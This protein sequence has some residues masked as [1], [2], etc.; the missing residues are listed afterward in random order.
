MATAAADGTVA[1]NPLGLDGFEF[2]EFTSPDPESLARLFE[3]LGFTHVA[4][5]R[6][7]NVRR[8]AQGDINF[9]LNAEP[10]GQ[11][12]EFR[13]RH[14][15]SANA[16]AF[17]VKDAAHAFREAV[18]RGAEPVEGRV[19]PMELNIPAIRGIGGAYLYLV[20]RYGAAE[21]YDVDF[22]PVPGAT[23]N[24]RSVGLK[25]IDHLTHNVAQGDLDRWAR[26]YERIFGFR[27]LRFFDIRGRATG[28]FSKAMVAP[29]GKI[30]I[31]L[32]ESQD[33]HSQIAEFLRQ[34]NGEGIQHVALATDDILATV[35]ALR[36]NGVRFQ[37]TPD[38]YYDL[39]DRR[40]P[41]HG[42]DVAA[43]KARRILVDGAPETGGGL[44]LQIFTENM[45][46]PIFFEIIQRMGNDGFGEG[47]F[48]ALFESLELDQIRRGVIPAGLSRVPGLLPG[49]KR[50]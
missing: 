10:D 32:N 2:V 37:D 5:H 49:A 7:K 15:P 18:R 46:G 9:I 11:P 22:R 35:D 16:L 39:L 23:K 6:S 47:N 19:G 40:L 8:Y 14:G 50:A 24:D 21:I 31:P 13:Q 26:F 3:R 48:Q 36:A 27:E 44:L 38:V 28:L 45:V 20:D 42:L 25:T 1:D 41:G 29:D 4:T 30:R 33:E 12:A 43:L 34:Y 17:R